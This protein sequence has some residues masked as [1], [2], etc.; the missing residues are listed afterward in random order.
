MTVPAAV[1]PEIFKNVLRVIFIDISRPPFSELG[2]ESETHP[3]QLNKYE[4]SF[5]LLIFLR[6]PP[7]FVPENY[8]DQIG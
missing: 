1:A 4:R 2:D 5:N 6:S 8:V 7:Q 3:L